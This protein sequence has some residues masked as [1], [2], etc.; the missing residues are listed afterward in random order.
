MPKKIFISHAVADKELA[1]VISDL[2]STGMGINAENDIFCTSLEGQSIPSGKNFVQYIK[3][4]IK[5]CK[6]IILLLTKNYFAS[7]FCLAEL[8]AS[9][10]IAEQCTHKNEEEVI[11]IPIVVSPVSRNELNSVLTGIQAR[12]I[13]DS[14]DWSEIGDEIKQALDID[15]RSSI[16][17]RKRDQA[18]VQIR[19]LT[20]KKEYTT[21]IPAAEHNKLKTRY[22]DAQEELEEME[23][24]LKAKDDLIKK[25]E[26]AKNP[27]EINQIRLDNM[28]EYGAFKQLCSTFGQRLS[29]L[30]WA[31]KE[32]IYYEN[33]GEYLPLPKFGEADCEDNLRKIQIA[34]DNKTL[35]SSTQNQY[36]TEHPDVEDAIN[37][38]EELSNY[39]SEHE[40]TL[41]PLLKKEWR[42]T[43]DLAD[44]TFWN[45]VT[46]H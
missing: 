28:D 30:D 9:W 35:S 39:M 16:W 41:A 31:T 19:D 14:S 45:E 24:Q 6:V 46:N 2:F 18:L 23:A 21:P 40:D 15:F 22:S 1:D 26:N 4:E 8:G 44:R 10:V 3:D 11:V 43:Y 12:K 7:H 33:K 32:A 20:E 13:E 17:E 42:C 37:A 36:N 5:G 25:I 29:K 34:L 27:D 38:L